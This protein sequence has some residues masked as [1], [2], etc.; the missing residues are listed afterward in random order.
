MVLRYLLFV[1]VW[2][3]CMLKVTALYAYHSPNRQLETYW[4]P[5]TGDSL[6][7]AWE[8]YQ[9]SLDCLER[10]CPSFFEELS[11]EAE[12]I[13]GRELD[14]NV[15]RGSTWNLYEEIWKSVLAGTKHLLIKMRTAV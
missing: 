9:Q 1:V 7:Y 13:F 2:L 3:G 14:K 6:E 11:E 10:K 15:F 12:K 8:L 5:F 4:E